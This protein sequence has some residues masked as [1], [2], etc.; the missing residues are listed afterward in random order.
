MYGAPREFSEFPTKLDE[1]NVGKVLDNSLYNSYIYRLILWLNNNL[2]GW[3]CGISRSS[4]DRTAND[5]G[6]ISHGGSCRH[7]EH[8]TGTRW[9]DAAS[10]EVQVACGFP[11]CNHD[12]RDGQAHRVRSQHWYVFEKNVQKQ[13]TYNWQLFE[14]FHS[15]I[16]HFRQLW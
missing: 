11:R 1:L 8:W 3:W 4:F 12:I 10:Q 7:Q 13:F 2:K 5:T 9:T 6:R 14:R 15:V 16:E